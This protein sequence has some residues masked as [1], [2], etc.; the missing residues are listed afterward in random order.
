MNMVIITAR[1]ELVSIRRVHALH[2]DAQLLSGFANAAFEDQADIQET[3]DLPDIGVLIFEREGRRAGD[4]AQAFHRGEGMDDRFGQTV[5]EI[6]L[7]LW[8]EVRERKNGDRSI[9]SG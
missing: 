5:V 1:P 7:R 8:A 3:A 4:D 2:V 6:L 9:V